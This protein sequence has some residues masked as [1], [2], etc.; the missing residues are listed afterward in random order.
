MV[1]W[2]FIN[3][4]Y[5]VQKIFIAANYREILHRNLARFLLF[6]P[7][8][9]MK[10]DPITE[11]AIKLANYMEYYVFLGDGGICVVKTGWVHNSQSAQQL[12]IE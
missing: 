2:C 5:D 8:M 6:S 10:V 12:P 3:M 1:D 11:K 4:T 9:G 7:L